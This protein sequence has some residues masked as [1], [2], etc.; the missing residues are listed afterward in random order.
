MVNICHKPKLVKEFGADAGVVDATELAERLMSL[1]NTA[2]ITVGKLRLAAHSLSNTLPVAAY[3]NAEIAEIVGKSART[4]RSIRRWAS[5]CALLPSSC[6]KKIAACSAYQKILKTKREVIYNNHEE[7]DALPP[8]WR[9]VFRELRNI[10]FNSFHGDITVPQYAARTMAWIERWGVDNVLHATWIADGP[11]GATRNKAGFV[12][13]LVEAGK[14]A[15]HGWTHP[16]L[17]ER[18]CATPMVNSCP[19][20]ATSTCSPGRLDMSATLP[21]AH[22][23][24]DPVFDVVLRTL[25]ETTRPGLYAKWFSQVRLRSKY[26]KVICWCPS[27][28]H[29]SILRGTYHKLLLRALRDNGHMEQIEYRAEETSGTNPKG[30]AIA[31][32]TIA[33]AVLVL[34]TLETFIRLVA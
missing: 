13:V 18:S 6:R 11:R 26:G 15:P 23:A 24:P 19:P 28:V 9:L 2:D 32:H 10:G 3:S 5:G 17:L 30:P 1:I 4:A 8:S 14:T 33:V 34:W 22:P 12:R 25:Q 27:Q 29:A 31:T 21:T 16:D 20:A 7:D